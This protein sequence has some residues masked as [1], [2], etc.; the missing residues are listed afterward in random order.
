M[1][2]SERLT[3]VWDGKLWKEFELNYP[4]AK[5]PFLSK[6]YNFALQ[7]NVDCFSP[8]NIQSRWHLCYHPKFAKSC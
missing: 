8:F 4:N 5:E 2:D 1:E 7:L 6:E 3:D